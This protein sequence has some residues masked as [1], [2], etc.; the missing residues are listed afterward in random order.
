M[1]TV[2]L[3]ALLCAA[4]LCA[5]GSSV[6]FSSFLLLIR[7]VLQIANVLAITTFP[8]ITPSANNVPQ[9]SRR[10]ARPVENTYSAVSRR[11]EIRASYGRREPPAVGLD[12]VDDAVGN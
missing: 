7:Y 1:E 6:S 2:K 10:L 4:V 11:V 3:A 5:S 12:N 9:F 8:G